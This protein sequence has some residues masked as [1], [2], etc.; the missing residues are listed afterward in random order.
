MNEA[1][2]YDHKN[3]RPLNLESDGCEL[4]EWDR[5]YGVA[6]FARHPTGFKV[7][8]PPGKLA[9]SDEY[10]D[11]DPYTVEQEIDSELPSKTDNDHNRFG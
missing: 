5:L 3:D 8:L 1:K 9:A 7:F 11:S 4:A 2:Y 10:A 6:R